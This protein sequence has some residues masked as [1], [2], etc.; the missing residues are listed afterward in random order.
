MGD[1]T[2]VSC[3]QGTAYEVWRD[4]DPSP[5]C[6]HRYAAPGEYAV[7]ATSY[8]D[9][10]W[11]GAG[12]SGTITFTLSQGSSVRVSEAFALVTEQG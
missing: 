4:A 3:G 8:W 1:G 2:T 6:G 5:T 7:T 11:S 10:D 9:V 12:Q